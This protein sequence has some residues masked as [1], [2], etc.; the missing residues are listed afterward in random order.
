MPR[1]ALLFIF[2]LGAYAQNSTLDQIVLPTDKTDADVTLTLPDAPPKGA[3]VTLQPL[4]DASGKRLSP[5]PA[6]DSLKVTDDVV[7]FHVTNVFFWGGAR[8]GVEVSGVTEPYIYT[9]QR[10]PIPASGRIEVERGKPAVIWLYNS[11]TQPYTAKWR[12]VS[13]AE[14]LCGNDANGKP[15]GGCG[16]PASQPQVTLAPAATGHI[17]FEAPDDW[18]GA[19]DSARKAVLE[20][21]FGSS[22][23]TSDAAPV[24]PVPVDL[25]ISGVGLEVLGLWF[26]WSVSGLS[27]IWHLVWVT[28]GV[29]LGAVFLMLAQVMIPN[30]RKCLGMENQVE[31]LEER[32]RG[33]SAAVGNRLSMRCNQEIQSVRRGL[34]MGRV[35]A[36]SPFTL[37]GVFL[38]GNTEEVSRLA[39]I[40]PK[41]ES[42]V[43]LTESLDERQ[44]STVEAEPCSMPPSLCWS[45]EEHLRSVESILAGQFVTD[46]DEKNATA[47]LDRLADPD[48]SLKDFTTDLE[49]RVAG[50]RRLFSS[51]PWKSK[52]A[53]IIGSPG[54]SQ[55]LD[56]CVDLLS[57]TTD[58]VPDGGWTMDEL[59]RRDLA[60][61]KLSIVNQMIELE[62]LLAAAPEVLAAVQLKI[63]SNDPG[64][65]ADA[66]IELAKISQGVSS[67][68]VVTALRDGMWDALMEPATPTVTDQDVVRVT[69]VFRDKRVDRS[70]AR[71][72]FQC[73]WHISPDDNYEEDWE[74]QFL[75]SRGS[76]TVEPEVYDSV[77]NKVVIRPTTEPEK[78]IFKF[79]VVQSPSNALH[80]RLLRGLLDATITA[81][82][83]VITVALTQVQNGGALGLDKLVLLGF[84][85]QAIRAAVIPDPAL[86][87]AGA[88][89]NAKVAA[90]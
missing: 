53:A 47:L 23:G 52:C 55:G 81:V 79:D 73:S 6:I 65:L 68:D 17:A 69:L 14:S 42:R 45:R 8:L 90:K 31:R 7:Q 35:T 36:K 46:V 19:R 38:S 34:G 77:G 88:T 54:A 25:Q 82:V 61:V 84:T 50:I 63:R 56:E 13:G 29:T 24:Y 49:L 83:P 89:T 78:G 39:G 30:F 60:A 58:T 20:L 41:V 22:L 72:S 9:L 86:P 75:L 40:L 4:L 67:Q 10:G 33:I 27:M 66:N 59:I 48:A 43:R 18:F 87:P 85:S 51:D 37:D 70:A 44:T 62:A 5:Q 76:V 15:H 32:M 26:P 11:G 3:T 80:A 21:R 16:S 71:N 74:S 64:V 1:L 12:I 28:F 57:R 2:A